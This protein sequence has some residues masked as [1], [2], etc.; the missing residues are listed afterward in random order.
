MVNSLRHALL[1]IQLTID[2]QVEKVDTT[3]FIK[4]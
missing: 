3:C 1:S 4:S 2:Q